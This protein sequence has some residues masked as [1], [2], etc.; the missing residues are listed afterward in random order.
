MIIIVDIK[1]EI[2]AELAR[3]AAAH[4]RAV[5]AYAANL[6]EE[7]V[8]FPSSSKGPTFDRDAHKLQALASASCAKELRWEV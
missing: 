4:G 3:R 1:P 7:A 8:Q 6:L 5:E 2:Q